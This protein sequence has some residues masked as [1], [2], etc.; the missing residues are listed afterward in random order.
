MQKKILVLNDLHVGSAYGL[1]PPAF[2]DTEGNV[3]EY[4]KGQKWLWDTFIQALNRI[5]PQPIDVIVVNGDVMDGKPGKNPNQS[6]DC[7]LHRIEDQRECA[8]KVLEEVKSRF[9]KAA[10]YFVQ[11][12]PNHETAADVAQVAFMLLGEKTP[13]RQTLS[14]QMGRPGREVI[15]Q[16]HH[17]TS[18]TSGPTKSGA[19]ERDIVNGFLAVAMDGWKSAACVIRAHCHYFVA[20]MRKNKLGIVCPCWQLQTPFTRKS[21]PDKT[22]PDIGC[23]VL[24]VDDALVEF[25]TCPVGFQEYIYRHPQSEMVALDEEE[26]DG[27][28]LTLI[29]NE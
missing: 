13:V 17:E 20:V 29:G 25:G 10:W 8:V 28:P 23:V 5:Q 18:F 1:F 3:H 12:T 27:T 9:P 11:G 26:P 19:I 22:I 4:S 16:F 2:V 24:S 6:Q 15:L 21:S 14:L 7:T